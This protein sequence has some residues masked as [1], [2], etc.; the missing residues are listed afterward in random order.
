MNALKIKTNKVK[1]IIESEHKFEILVGEKLTREQIAEVV[2]LDKKVYESKYLTNVHQLLDRYKA[3]TRSFIVVYNE[4]KN[5][6]GYMNLYPVT[7]KLYDDIREVR[8]DTDVDISSDDI[9][10]YESGGKYYL[11]I[12]SVVVKP[13]YQGTNVSKLLSKGFQE[14][15]KI[16]KEKHVTIE[17][18]LAIAVSNSGARFSKKLGLKKKNVIK[19]NI[20]LEL[21]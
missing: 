1:Q 11:Y 13:K 9:L 18:V 15:L 20:I 4:K 3:N 10:P 21:K 8:L 14:Y 2:E 16:C 6:V 5:I 7:D 12:M 19:G 17:N